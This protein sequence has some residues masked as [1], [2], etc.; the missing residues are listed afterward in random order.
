MSPNITLSPLAYQ[1]EAERVLKLERLA[2]ADLDPGSA[3]R[4][5]KLALWLNAL[6]NRVS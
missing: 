3:Q 1:R 5:R 6:A 2:R 4:L